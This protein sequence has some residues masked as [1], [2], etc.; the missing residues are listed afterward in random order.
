MGME[1]VLTIICYRSE[2]IKLLQVLD[3]LSM[4]S[5]KNPDIYFMLAPETKKKYIHKAHLIVTYGDIDS[6]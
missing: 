2:F 1:L 6:E 3:N 5:M 4:V